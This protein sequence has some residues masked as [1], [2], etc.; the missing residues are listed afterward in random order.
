M[1]LALTPLFTYAKGGVKSLNG[2]D[3]HLIP[4]N[5]KVK[6]DNHFDSTF[7]AFKGVQTHRGFGNCLMS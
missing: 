4:V 3:M 2:F 5:G 6:H 1:I 7:D